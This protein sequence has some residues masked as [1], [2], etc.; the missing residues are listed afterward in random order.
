MSTASRRAARK[1][2]P[3]S[4]RGVPERPR[5]G[6]VRR[7]TSAPAEAASGLYGSTVGE[8]VGRTA[9]AE[10]LG[11][12]LLVL[13]GTSVATAMV[14]D[15]G[16]YSP[17]VIA[18]AFGLALAALVAGLGHVSGCHVN[19]AV[20]IGLA[21][22]RSFP[23]KYVPAYVGAQ[24]AG[25]VLASLFVWAAF[26]DGARTDGARL[27]AS[28]P[29][30]GTGSGRALL[31]EAVITFLLVFVV[32][33]VATDERVPKAAAPLAVGAALA[34]AVLVGIPVTGGAVNPARAF[35]P[36]LVTGW[37]PMAWL[38]LVGPVVGG[39][40]GAVVYDKV[41]RKADAPS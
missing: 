20:T 1:D 19:P 7:S 9:F 37:F 29:G 31:V 8:N 35:G 30:A 40:L 5:P 16:L 11:T 2:T 38:Y 24:L 21:A 6:D 10:F 33:S 28:S 3:T 32:C 12:F 13:V 25:G 41:V 17:A 23:W 22:T 18:V 15:D 14:E 27:G 34:A 36:F 39:V 4:R 26:G